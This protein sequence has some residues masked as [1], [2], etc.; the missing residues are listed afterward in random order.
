MLTWVR[1]RIEYLK[2]WRE[3]VARLARAVR[4]IEPQAKVYVF[5]SIARGVATVL[6]DVDVLVVVPGRRSDRELR[7]IKLEIFSR[8]VDV[9]RVPWDYPFDIHVVDE[10]RL[11]EYLKRID[12][13]VSIG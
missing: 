11:E 10:G 13:L 6:S 1:R 7:R 3:H 2:M 8:A 12:K 9:Y 5:G 4:D